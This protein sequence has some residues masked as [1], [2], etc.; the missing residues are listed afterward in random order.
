MNKT[1]DLKRKI[2]KNRSGKKTKDGAKRENKRGT[3][4]MEP[5]QTQIAVAKGE[6]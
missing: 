3:E 1:K 5:I 2:I 6:Y 4:T